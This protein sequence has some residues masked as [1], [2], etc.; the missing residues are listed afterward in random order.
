MLAEFQSTEYDLGIAVLRTAQDWMNGIVI[1]PGSCSMFRTALLREVGGFKSHLIAED[2]AA[3]MELRRRFP[4]MRIR[5]DLTAV[6]LTEVPLT[7]KTLCNQWRRWNFGVMQV[8]MDHREIFVR[9]DKYGGLTL[10]LWWSLYGLI[11]PTLLLPVTYLMI[12]VTA[13]DRSW[14][15]LLIYPLIFIVYRIATTI[16]S[17]IIMREW[18]NPFTAIWYRIINDP[19]QIYLAVTCWYKVLSGNVQ[20]RKIWSKIPR[21]GVPQGESKPAT[22]VAAQASGEESPPPG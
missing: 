11:V 7:V 18:M 15:N 22:Q 20:S 19:L 2:A 14:L 10:Q 9:P 13:F 4:G 5:Q 3:G 1:V 6:A 17:M 21:Q 8:M 16:V 12:V